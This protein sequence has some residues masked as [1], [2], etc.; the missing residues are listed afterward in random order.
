MAEPSSSVAR[1]SVALD[2]T[3]IPDWLEEWKKVMLGL[4]SRGGDGPAPPPADS[5]DD[6][7]ERAE[8]TVTVTPK[9]NRTVHRKL[10]GIHL[11]VG[12]RAASSPGPAPRSD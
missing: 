8:C 4:G 3:W 10:N 7:F 11:S 6:G 2:P 1:A 12:P 5:D 9:A